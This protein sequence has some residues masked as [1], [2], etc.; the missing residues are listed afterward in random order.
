MFGIG[1][2]R[3]GAAAPVDSAAVTCPSCRADAPAGARFC[4]SCGQD[5]RLRGDER[6]VVT[7]LFADLVGY[8]ALSESRDP[9]QVKNL[10]DGCF[11]RLVADIDAFGGRVDKI[12]G[13]AIVAL[14][15][16]PIAH[17][18]D[19]ERA[20]RA[21][22]RMQESLARASDELGVGVMMR[23]GV[24]TGEVLVGA[25]R[26]GGDYTA[27]GDVV[28]TANRLQTSAR[29]GEVLVGPSTFAA[30]RRSVR[31][32]PL[33]PLDVKGREQ[34]VAAWRA[35][36]ALAP[37]G[38]RPGRG[39]A[40]LVGRE[41]EMGVLCSTVENTIDNARASLL[42]LLG[43][44]GVGKSRLAEE[45]AVALRARAQHP[46]PRGAV[47]ALRRGQRVVAHRRRPAP[48]RRDPF[49]RPGRPGR[50]AGPHRRVHRAR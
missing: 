25:L 10:V 30:T 24:N 15:G 37:P 4:A 50:G 11:E 19:A 40:R 5:L 9:E 42:L 48:R 32:E 13:D 21:A 20:V 31:Y 45:L 3:E 28:N 36:E 46:H 43:E 8:T 34:T 49:D 1:E 35:E 22:L 26:A 17:E 6:R 44:A 2:S 7:V 14:F 18:D 38:Y 27:M 33:E 12:I 16:A 29:P 47:R 39:R 41:A 23:V